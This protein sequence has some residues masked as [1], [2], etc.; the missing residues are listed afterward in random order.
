VALEKSITTGD[1]LSQRELA[2]R[3]GIPRSRASVIAREV[4]AAAAA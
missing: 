3:Y 4:S 1:P 2:R